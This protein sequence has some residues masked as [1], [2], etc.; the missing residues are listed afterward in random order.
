[1]PWQYFVTIGVVTSRSPMLWISMS[2]VALLGS[3]MICCQGM[4]AAPLLFKYENPPLLTRMFGARLCHS[5]VVAEYHPCIC[6][7][8]PTGLERFGAGISP[9]NSTIAIVG[10]DPYLTP[11]TVLVR[12]AMKLRYWFHSGCQLAEDIVY[13]AA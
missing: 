12:L 5:A 10:S 1:M 13:P 2:H 6:A 8:V 4:P 3:R 11:V 7:A 9:H